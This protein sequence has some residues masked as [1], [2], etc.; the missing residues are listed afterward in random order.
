MK[1]AVCRRYG[2]PE[3]VEI[4]EVPTPEPKGNEV[5]IRVR[6]TTV[7]SADW[8]MRSLD[9]PKGFG[10]FG[11]LMLGILRPRQPVLGTELAGEIASVGKTVTRWKPGDRVFAFP[12]AGGGAHAEF[13]VMPEDGKL[14]AIPDGLDWATAAALSFGGTTALDFLRDKA[15]LKAGERVLVVGASGAVGNAAVQIA[16][17]L[18]AH[19]TGVT[20]GGNA[21]LVRELG[22]DAVIDYGRED[23][24][25]MEQRWDVILNASDHVRF[26]DAVKVLNPG[27]RLVLV[28]A[29]LPQ[30][31]QSL[32]PKRRDGKRMVVGVAAERPADLRLLAELA[33]RGV[34][35]PLIDS[36][37]PFERI[38]EAHA[39]VDTGRKRGSVV[40]FLGG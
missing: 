20:S 11:R 37:F 14:A 9:L 10:L 4:V 40:V 7:S 34:Y 2:P 30:M 6:A 28:L 29:S 23:F 38:V 39:R 17:H 32:L 19:V 18:G 31:L 24:R 5:L 15:G 8:R 33:A 16:R 26:A 13:R 36:T 27:G 12:G 1:A 35:K 21:G 25:Q 22:A 3:V